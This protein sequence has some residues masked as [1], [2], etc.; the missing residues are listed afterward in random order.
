MGFQ[1]ILLN[2]LDQFPQALGCDFFHSTLI[3]LRK[4]VEFLFG[5][6][7]SA[8]RVPHTQSGNVL[9]PHLPLQSQGSLGG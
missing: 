8:C 6:Q 2:E 4:F 5:N 1:V 9:H 3:G 7:N